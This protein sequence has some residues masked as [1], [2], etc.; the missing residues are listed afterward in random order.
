MKKLLLIVLALTFGFAGMSQKEMSTV[1]SKDMGIKYTYH[2]TGLEETDYSY[3]ADAKQMAVFSNKDGS[4]YW[5]KTFKE[6]APNIKKI[7]ELVPFWESNIIFLF[8]RKAGKDQI[9]CIDLT[10]GKLLWTTDKYQKVTADMIVYIE[11]DHGFAISLK[12]ELVYIKAHT[13]EEIWSTSKFSGVVGKYVYNPDDQTL[14][15]VNFIPSGIVAFFTGF[16]NQIARIN[17][18]TGEVVWENTYIGRADKKVVTGDFIYDL[19]L[20][21]DKVILSLAG[22]QVYD[23]NTGATLWSAAFD[24]TP[25]VVKPPKGVTRWGVYGAVADPVIVGDDI[26]VLDMTDK[27]N[28][29]I[30]KYDYHT[31][32]LLWTS[33]EIKGAKA[34]PGMTVVGDVVAIQVG[35]AV[36]VQYVQK[37]VTQY[38]TFYYRVVTYS[39]VKPY[40]VQAFNT[41]DGSK[42][43]DSE[44]FKKGITNAIAVGNSHIVCSGKSLYSIDIETG[45]DNYEVPVSKGGVGLAQMILPYGDNTIVVVGEKGLSTFNASDGSLIKKSPFKKSTLSGQIGDIVLMKTD[46]ADFAVYDLSTMDYTMYDAR[47]GAQTWLEREDAKYVYVYEKKTVTKLSTH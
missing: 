7:D 14:T 30:K 19:E 32:K 5:T 31:G 21:D 25:S 38:Y 10:N 43:W 8:D 28:Q 26:Y 36:E 9:A 39:G 41:S 3:V 45:N 37:V 20:N 27:K 44:R 46:K 15:M 17:M 24:Y 12:K 18:K 35:G 29:Y 13:G 1:W 40:G 42:R 34:I 33:K 22:I 2:G 4:I 6:I 11:E 47:K 23:Y 16:K